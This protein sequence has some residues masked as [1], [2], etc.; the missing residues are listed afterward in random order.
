[1]NKRDMTSLKDIADQSVEVWNST[2]NPLYLQR[3][4]EQYQSI[5]QGI[6]EMASTRTVLPGYMRDIA[7]YASSQHE[8]IKAVLGQKEEKEPTYH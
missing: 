3:A 7:K 5:I 6:E 8:A 4:F 1:M 2:R